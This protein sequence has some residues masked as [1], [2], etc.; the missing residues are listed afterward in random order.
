[1][2][3]LSRSWLG[4]EDH[5]LEHRLYEEQ[6]GILNWALEGLER[7]TITNGNRFTR[8]ASA[9]EAI[10]T[11]RDL[12]SPVA[13]FVRE[14]CEIAADKEVDVDRL[15][16]AYK[17]WCEDGEHPKASKQIFGRDLR[18]AVPSVRKTRPRD[19]IDRGNSYAG[20]ALRS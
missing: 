20:I 18:A 15:Y 2:L 5:E 9:E 3:L 19:G 17:T 10:I 14:K 4:K 6:S 16:A 8:L 13:A 7:L 1:L 11:M 12:A